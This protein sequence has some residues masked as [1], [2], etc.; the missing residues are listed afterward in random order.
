MEI[1]RK[2]HNISGSKE[3][4]LYMVT[5]LDLSLTNVKKEI[6]RVKKEIRETKDEN[7]RL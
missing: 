6:E 2:L 4:V 3:N 7:K 1:A 5:D